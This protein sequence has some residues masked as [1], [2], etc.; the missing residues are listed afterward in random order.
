MSIV[1][2]LFIG[3]VT[4]IDPC[5]IACVPA[6]L[7]YLAGDS[8]FSES[9]A[10]VPI[11]RSVLVKR[12]L[13]FVAGFSTLFLVIGAAVIVLGR[14]L[15]QVIPWISTV[16]AI[17]M[18][19]I[20]LALLGLLVKPLARFAERIKVSLPG[21][22][23]PRGAYTFGLSIAVAWIPCVGPIMAAVVVLAG[24]T[25]Q[26]FQGLLLLIAFCVGLSIPFLLVALGADAILRRLKGLKRL[27]TVATA[28]AGVIMVLIGF[29]VLTGR[30]E[31]VE[32]SVSAFYAKT[33]PTIYSWRNPAQYEEWWQHVFGGG[34]APG[35]EQHEKGP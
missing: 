17:L 20:G 29:L 24:V 2:A 27:V 19:L 3:L 32:H 18:I 11:T 12:T 34:P 14:A 1:F 16:G 23:S 4:F 10:K 13:F 9:G 6:Y 25:Q 31:T 15:S 7:G 5:V 26:V 35:P 30:Y 33:A 28:V 22:Q 8:D 21:L